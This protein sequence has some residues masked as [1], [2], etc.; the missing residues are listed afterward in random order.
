MKLIVGLGNPGKE[1]E[2]TRHNVGFNV[3]DLYLKQNKLELDKSKFNGKYTKTTINDEEVIFLEPQTYM[4]NSGESVQA[5]MKF[6][7]ID[8]NDI[9]VIQDDLDMEIGK[10]KLKEK[11]SSGGHN[12]IKSIEE[13]LGTDNYKRLKIGISNNKDIDTKD[14]VLGKFSKED[15]DILDETY[16]T[17]INIIGDYF[18]MNFDL[19]MGKYNKR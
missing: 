1:Y 18:K 5:I 17:C 15:R 6:Y 13:C 2:K 14:Y 16:K 7:K 8:I 19:L 10:I 11:S 4:N 12:G 3:V 9:L